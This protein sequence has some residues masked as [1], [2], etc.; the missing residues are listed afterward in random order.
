MNKIESLKDLFIEQGR[1]LYDAARQEQKELP[2]LRQQARNAELKKILD[3]QIAT[4]RDQ[5]TRIEHVFKKMNV[6]PEGVKS[7]CCESLV[8]RA[9]QMANQS[10]ISEV[11][12]AAII[13]SVQ[14]LNHNKITGFGSLTAYASEIGH[15]DLATALH[16]AL[17]EERA[18]DEDLSRLAQ[19]E[20]NKK[21]EMATAK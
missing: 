5:A 10:V 1:E 4:A 16:K 11:R 20:I 9:R 3:R 13:N 2:S 21:A 7:A 12:D 18:I 17:E 6:S 8:S 15:A 19:T 14:R